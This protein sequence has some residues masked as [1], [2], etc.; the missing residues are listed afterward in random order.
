MRL[1]GVGSAVSSVFTSGKNF[2]V[3]DKT[4]FCRVG[5]SG[6][7]FLTALGLSKNVLF[8]PEAK[9]FGD[10]RFS[11]KSGEFCLNLFLIL[12]CKHSKSSSTSLS[13][14]AL[15]YDNKLINYCYNTL[16]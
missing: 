13:G 14:T 16:S 11:L 9:E 5:E 4:L 12:S 8:V 10:N 1:G 6:V 3:G 2:L 7:L 15:T